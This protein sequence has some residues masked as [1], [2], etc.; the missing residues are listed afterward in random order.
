MPRLDFKKDKPIGEVTGEFEKPVKTI[1]P[2]PTAEPAEEALTE[3]TEK[4][5]ESSGLD[6]MRGLFPDETVEET[7]AKEE[8]SAP[9]ESITF[10]EEPGTS[11]YSGRDWEDTGFKSTFPNKKL[12]YI[13]GGGIL[14]VV[15][16]IFVLISFFSRGKEV[17]TAASKPP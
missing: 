7:P 13:L 11:G 8:P 16:L 10:A 12:Y 2:E 1:A 4:S 17:E 14:L 6:F 9:A 3:S 5:T 15:L